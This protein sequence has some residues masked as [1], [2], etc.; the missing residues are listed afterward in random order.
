MKRIH[1]VGRKNH[2]KTTLIAELLDAFRRQGV[3]VGSIKHSAHRHELDLPGKDSYRHRE[4][5]ANPAAVICRNMVGVFVPR[6]EATDAYA[7]IAPLFADCALV[8]VE[9]D[10]DAAA[11]KI[12]VWRECQGTSCLAAE[13]D[14]ILA[15]VSDDAPPTSLPVWPRRGV[16]QIVANLLAMVRTQGD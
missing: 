15:V 5:G 9:G 13:R 3:R 1:I 12:E 16:A 2:G 10:I 11:P 14:D 4:A 6:D 7:S 8:L